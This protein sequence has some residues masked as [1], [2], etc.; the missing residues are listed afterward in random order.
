MEKMKASKEWKEE[1]MAPETEG[2]IKD[3]GAAR[4]QALYSFF[5]F[6]FKCDLGF[7]LGPKKVHR[8]IYSYL[9]SA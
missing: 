2:E 3:T 1:E 9:A 4:M 6:L 7:L 5:C 8:K